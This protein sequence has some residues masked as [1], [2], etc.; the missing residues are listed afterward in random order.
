MI[1]NLIKGKEESMYSIF[2]ILVG[3]LFMQHGLQKILGMFGGLGGNSAQFMT[4]MWFAG[5]IELVGGAFI[6]LG[7]FTRLASLISALEMAVAYFQVHFPQGMIPIMNSGELAVLFFAC[8]IV[9]TVQGAK[10]WS[11]EKLILNKEFF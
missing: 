10:R 7:L 5:I 11:L 8:F 9:I 3:L 1:K 6:F 4:Q 2:R